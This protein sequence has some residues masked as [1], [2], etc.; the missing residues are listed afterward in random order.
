M[1]RFVLILVFHLSFLVRGALLPSSVVLISFPPFASSCLP[2]DVFFNHVVIRGFVLALLFVFIL[3]S[4][5]FLP[6][7]YFSFFLLSNSFASLLFLSFSFLSLAT[8]SFALFSCTWHL[9]FFCLSLVMELRSSSPLAPSS[10]L[11]LFLGGF[12]IFHRP[13]CLHWPWAFPLSS[14]LV[15]PICPS[16]L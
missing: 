9:F 1:F 3:Y 8:L 10:N 12:L 5:C 7:A 6:W 16:K 2:F 13:F 11:R 15:R 14:S 4:I